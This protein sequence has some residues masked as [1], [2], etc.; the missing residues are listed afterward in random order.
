[1]ELKKISLASFSFVFL[2]SS[3][4]ANDGVTLEPNPPS[5]IPIDEVDLTITSPTNGT[6]TCE[7]K[8]CATSFNKGTSITLTA[9]PASGYKLSSWSIS[10]CNG[11]PET[12]T[13]TMD[14][15][16]TVSATFVKDEDAK[17]PILSISPATE[18][19]FSESDGEKSITVTNTGTGN[20]TGIKAE[21]NNANL[22]FSIT[23]G[24]E[25][26]NLA[27][28]DNG[29]TVKV[30]F[31][32]PDD[33][34]TDQTATLTISATD[35]D[36]KTVSLIGK[37]TQ[38]E[39]NPPIINKFEVPETAKAGDEITLEVNATDTDANDTLTY[40]WEFNS[41]SITLPFTVP[42][43][44]AAGTYPIKVTV[45]DSNGGT[46]SKKKEIIIETKETNPEKVTLNIS[47][48]GSGKIECN[49]ETCPSPSTYPVGTKLTLTA[50]AE[51]DF[52]FDSWGEGA[53]KSAEKDS[54][55]ELTTALTMSK[56]V[57]A[58][59]TAKEGNETPAQLSIVDKKPLAFTQDTL[60][61]SITVMNSGTTT[62]TGINVTV[63]APFSTNG[64]TDDINAESECSL[65]ITFAPDQ[66][67]KGIQ[68]TILTISA[69]T[70]SD[71]SIT[72]YSTIHPKLAQ[73]LSL[74]QQGESQAVSTEFFSGISVDDTLMSEEDNQNLTKGQ[75]MV[76]N[77]MIKPDAQHIGKQAEIIVV[78][79]VKFEGEI[80]ES[81]DADN[82][83]PSTGY[84]YMNT[85][86]DDL[87]CTWDDS[88]ANK[89]CNPNPNRRSG[90]Y[91]ADNYWQRW[92]GQL[93]TLEPLD[94]ITLTDAVA[95]HDDK[96]L[97]QD[98]LDYQAHVCINFGYRLE[99]GTLVFNGSP[100]KYRVQ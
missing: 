3:V 67:T 64:C 6:I 72:L 9:E 51:E 53:C 32:Q 86:R 81:I 85:Q 82:C 45:T 21:L 74:N 27:A 41:K 34:T 71:Q 16:K 93:D 39:N 61:H 5:K 76:V 78:G 17:K 36:S 38:S 26:A 48:T 15:D 91:T 94:T 12:C 87:Y 55:C 37:I 70:G 92:N 79:L 49:N 63:D 44:T 20:L 13:I 98:D 62:A 88:T 29:C 50:I 8:T 60:S 19:T 57:K 99:D 54:T 47:V 14:K 1:M 46:D 89:T 35:I 40:N 97:Y 56:N 83:D 96:V 69:D 66:Q 28:S 4:Y 90:N 23:N 100:I 18:L 31:K 95:L 25:N 52:Q 42:D 80:D 11:T 68:Q 7:G 33:A 24:C 30:N 10:N 59:F 2:C 65:T 75:K 58:I 84:Y 22:G 77:G 43:T 73:V